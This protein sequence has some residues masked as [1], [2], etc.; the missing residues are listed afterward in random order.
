MSRIGR[1]PVLI[2]AGVEVTIDGQLVKVL[3]PKGALEH[4]V[5]EP[6]KVARVENGEL[7]VSR[8][9]DER[10]SKSLHGLTRTLVANMV[11]GVTDGYEKRLEIVGVGYRAALKGSDLEM[12][13]GFSHPVLFPAPQGIEFEVPA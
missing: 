8:P 9:D 7:E 12:A 2:P 1:M 10:E 13:L 4:R 6:I 5:A 11:T 3:G